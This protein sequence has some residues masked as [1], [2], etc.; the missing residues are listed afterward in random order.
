MPTQVAQPNPMGQ[1][2]GGFAQPMQQ[3]ATP[4]QQAAPQQSMPQAN[5]SIPPGMAQQGV[6]GQGQPM[7][8]AQMALD[9]ARAA[10][11]GQPPQ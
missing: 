10:A 6:A 8:R 7:N 3:M 1:T 2:P 4:M 5:M 11:A 9:A